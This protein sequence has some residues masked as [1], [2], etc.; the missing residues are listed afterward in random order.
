MLTNF[1]GD[2]KQQMF[3]IIQAKLNKNYLKNYPNQ[4]NIFVLFLLSKLK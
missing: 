1:V 4:E 3:Q 2:I